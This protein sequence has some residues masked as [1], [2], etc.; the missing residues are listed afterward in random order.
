MSRLIVKLF[1][2]YENLDGWHIMKLTLPAE[3]GEFGYDMMTL[4]ESD[5]DSCFL[6]DLSMKKFCLTEVGE[7]SISF[8]ID[9]VYT[10]SGEDEK[11]FLECG[12]S[13]T[14]CSVTEYGD[15]LPG[16]DKVIDVTLK[17]SLTVSLEKEKER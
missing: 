17:Y 7:N 11:H 12:A 14:F 1:D 8:I 13:E 16:V 9:H 3:V 10:E 15:F 5:G 2:E 4:S 6:R